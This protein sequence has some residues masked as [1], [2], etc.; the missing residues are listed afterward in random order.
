MINKIKCPKCGDYQT[1]I[2]ASWGIWK[3][4][5]CNTCSHVSAIE[6]KVIVNAEETSGRIASEKDPQ[7]S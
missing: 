4:I 1:E 3:S 2:T 5:F 6:E 7:S